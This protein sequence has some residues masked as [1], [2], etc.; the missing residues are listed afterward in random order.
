MLNYEA[1]MKN[2]LS[3]IWNLLSSSYF[4]VILLSILA[5]VSV[6][7]TV[8]P[9]KE[10]ADTYLK[11]FGSAFAPL[12]YLLQLNDLFSSLFF[13]ALA[14]LLGISL[15]SCSLKRLRWAL[16][17]K[18]NF[19]LWGS[20]IA[21]LSILLIY[22]GVI[23]G[24]LA[25]FK[26]EV[27]IEKGESYFEARGNFS[28]RLNDFNAKFDKQGRPLMFSS[29][30]SV[31]E[32][33]KEVLRKTI[34]VNHPLVYK[35]VKFYQSSYGLNGTL[36]IKKAGGKPEIIPIYK[37]GCATYSE[38]GQ[39]FH[40]AELIPDL[41]LLHG[42]GSDTFEPL[43]PFVQLSAHDDRYSEEIGWVGLGQAVPW[44]GYTL[45]LIGVKEYTGLSIRQDPGIPVVY[46]GFLFLTAGVGMMLY[47]RRG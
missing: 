3:K 21:H 44:Q 17:G 28:V 43:N 27:G 22:S 38:T 34:S 1:H 20:F 19:Y 7:G 41:N 30:L 40:I 29:D 8:I 18:L 6:L 10:S 47:I 26:T 33:E 46:L 16:D 2:S 4:A 25:G 39:M 35:G 9:Q 36:E 45:K 15:F 23:Y 12:F 13:K 32:G 31:I 11:L 24:G 14:T 5:A 42:M 37:G